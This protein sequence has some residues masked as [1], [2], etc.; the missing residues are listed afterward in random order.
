MLP[1]F[2]EVHQELPARTEPDP[3]G[4]AAAAVRQLAESAGLRPGASVAITSG[5]RGIAR[6]AEITGTVVAELDRLGM[7]PF[8]VPAMGSHGGGTAEG[9]T[10]VLASYGISE[11]T[12]NAPVRSSMEAERVGETAEGVP[13][14]FDR[15]SMGADA[16]I[17]LN[18]VKPHTILRGELGSGLV[19]MS[20]IGLGK[21]IG[22]QTIHT[23]GLQ[24][25]VVP[26]AEVLLERTPL[27]GG[28]AI[29]EN[30]EGQVASVEAVARGDVVQRDKELLQVARS[31]MPHLPIEPLDVLVVRRMGKNLSGTGIDPNVI[32]M[33]RRLGGEPDHDID[34]IV[35]LDLTDDSHGNATGI[36][37]ADVITH[38]LRDK[39]D[40]HATSVNSLTSQFVRG[41]KLPWS[42][43][44]D[45]EAIELAASQFDPATVRMAV[46]DDT[47]HI[48]RV[49]LSEALLDEARRTEGVTVTGE[50]GSLPFEG[51]GVLGRALGMA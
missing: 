22:A 8:I 44:T 35:V 21:H 51:D 31:F 33:H 19:K 23:R 28:I 9:Q 3:L 24:R 1:R 17:A 42:V 50:P 10:E 37:M 12:M 4:A 39:I 7:K 14:H 20:S 15:I 30:G 47:L 27:A 49:W 25:H 6:I 32:G 13:A 40:W 45:Q 41:L 16:V 26:V 11:Q 38:R 43:P 34:T 29:V 2:F 48:T 46:I 5:S 36:G 18:R